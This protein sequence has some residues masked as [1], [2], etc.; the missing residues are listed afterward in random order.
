[1]STLTL[2]QTT[3]NL[4]STPRV[5]F[6]PAESMPYVSKLIQ[7]PI[8]SEPMKCKR[9]I[10]FN[11][12]KMEPAPS[13]TKR[14]ARERNRVKMVN[15]GFETLRDRVPSKS[16]SKK[17]SKVETLKSAVEYIKKL[18]LL[19]GGQNLPS[20][21]A[22]KALEGLE[23]S[24][25]L[26]EL[27]EEDMESYTQGSVGSPETSGASNTTG[28]LDSPMPCSYG[29]ESPPYFVNRHSFQ[30]SNA[31][32]YYS[33]S[34]RPT[35]ESQI[36]TSSPSSLPPS[37]PPEYTTLSNLSPSGSDACSP[38]P[39]YISDTSNYENF[40]PEEQELVLLDFTKWLS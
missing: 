3:S 1:M 36:M 27:D 21:D 29:Q 35:M 16:K 15:K 24:F 10:S 14:N 37:S 2:L 38:T 22:L 39:S 12:Q 25:E 11:N 30:T 5:T 9:K 28:S 13:V 33:P 7:K 32:Y 17:L 26:D 23:E 4:T 34:S 8:K 18:R 19:L 6:I 20:D 31:S 40:S